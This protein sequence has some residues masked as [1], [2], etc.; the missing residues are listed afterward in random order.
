MSEVGPSWSYRASIAS[1]RRHA[2]AAPATEF[3][4]H[5]DCKEQSPLQPQGGKEPVQRACLV[6]S[7]FQSWPRYL[8]RLDNVE[9]VA[10]FGSSA[11]R[12]P[13]HFGKDRHALLV[14][15][16]SAVARRV[17]DVDRRGGKG[18]VTGFDDHSCIG[19][20]HAPASV[21]VM[22]HRRGTLC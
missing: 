15:A 14:A 3:K 22:H 5:T 7:W 10:R 13:R 18:I 1:S 11:S 16:V 2:T 6:P 8:G 20:C 12:P 4:T 19:R 21:V 17:R 9:L